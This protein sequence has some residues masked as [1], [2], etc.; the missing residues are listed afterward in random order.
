VRV[1]VGGVGAGKKGRRGRKRVC[2]IFFCFFLCVYLRV[3]RGH[4]HDM[5]CSPFWRLFDTTHSYMTCR[6]VTW[7]IHIW[8]VR[9]QNDSFIC[10]MTHL[11]V[12]YSTVC[13]MPHT[14][15][16]CAALHPVACWMLNMWHDSFICEHVTW[17][18]YMWTCDMTHLYVNMWHDSFICEHV[19][20]LI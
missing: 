9:V 16:M 1:C 11:Y 12:T 8:H 2:L 15:S 19:T 17:L 7:L 10:D 14:I 18:I 4:D 5:R 6:C 3:C 20:W 13:D